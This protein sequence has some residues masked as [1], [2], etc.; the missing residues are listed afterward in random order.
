MH[1][2]TIVLVLLSALLHAAW[3]AQLKSDKDQ[4]QFMS[5][6][7]LAVGVIS[8]L[9]VPLV[10][11]PGARS[12][13]CIAF[14]GALHILYNFLLLQK[15]KNADFSSAYPIS[16]GVSP[17]FVSLGAFLFMRQHLAMLSLTGISLIS[18]GIFL[19][20]TGKN[21]LGLRLT[22]PAFATGATIAAYTV[23]D[24]IGVQRSGNTA[25]YSVWIFASYL[26]VPALLRVLRFQTHLLD[27]ESMP[28][29]ACSGV[30]SLIAYTVVL[31]ATHSVA[32]GTVSA[33][34]ET[35]VLWAAAIGRVFLGEK[36][37]ER[38][39]GSAI[40]ICCGVILLVSSNTA[41]GTTE[42]SDFQPMVCRPLG[43]EGASRYVLQS[44][45]RF[46]ELA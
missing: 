28:K 26:F 13:P 40:L 41:K 46:T 21:R 32:V 27:R 19:Q 33:L 29:A 17:V 30:L 36:L 7:S 37:T 20:V 39:I 34:R 18:C 35:S 23:V 4:A 24:T 14:S 8:L 11:L 16:R 31:W 38:K 25:S 2:F 10:G 3:N 45:L 43:I 9:C 44:R 22:L 12:W 1:V 42:T 15:Y 5:S 6:M